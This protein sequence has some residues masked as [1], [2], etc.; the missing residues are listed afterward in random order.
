MR[1]TNLLRHR[2]LRP[3]SPSKRAPRNCSLTRRPKTTR[4][5]R[6]NR[7]AA[8]AR[9][10]SRCPHSSTGGRVRAHVNGCVRSSAYVLKRGRVRARSSCSGV[11]ELESKFEILSTD[12]R[13]LARIRART[14]VSGAFKLGHA[15]PKST[16]AF[17]LLRARARIVSSRARARPLYHVHPA[18]TSS[19]AYGRAQARARTGSIV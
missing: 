19:N 7:H 15:Y 12:A 2:A 9:W 8:Y 6:H 1:K 4:R 3:R 10:Q 18:R 5:Q 13:E 16:G 17:D 14:C 11:Y